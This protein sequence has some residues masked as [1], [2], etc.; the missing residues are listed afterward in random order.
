MSRGT[1]FLLGLVLALLVSLPARALPEHTWVVAI[2]HDQGAANEVGLLF[3]EQDAR[4][5][6]DVLRQHGG[7][8]SRRTMLLLGDDAASVRRALQ[9]VNAAIRSQAGAGH[10][11]AL[12]VFYSGHADAASLHLGGT[13][14]PFEELKALVEGSPAGV[15]LL[16]LDACRSGAVT[17]VKG[18]NAAQSFDISLRNNIATEGLAILTSSA[19]GESSQESD[20][21]RGSFFT[22]HLMN[23]LRGAAD[24]DDDGKVTLT[25]AYG[26]AYTQTLRSSGQ[27]VALQH[28][29][30]SWAVKGRGE[31]VLSTPAETQG[32]M[33]RVRLGSS[34]L[35]LILEGRRG[36]PVVAEV[37]PQGN[38][39]ELSLPA[40]HYFV[41]QRSADE[42]REYQVTLAAGAVAEVD[43]LP[44]ETVRYDRLVRRRGGEKRYTHH[45]SLLGGAQGEMLAGDGTAPQLRVGYGLDFDWG[46]VGVRLRGLR[47][48]SSGLDGLL[49][50]THDELG[51]GLTLQRFVDLAPVSLAFGLF[52]EGVYHRQSFDTERD[53]SN[54][55]ALGAAF[56]GIL[57][58]ERHL[59][60]GLA[61]RLEG[62]P[63]T[64]LFQRAV[65]KNGVVAEGRELATPLTWWGAGGLVWRR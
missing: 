51:L 39:R 59:G 7:V 60:A 11:T 38:R 54:R 30:Y 31:L 32:K 26:Y 41:Q 35:Y 21:L 20:E 2:G 58:V 61:L 45:V 55:Q 4:A 24:H 10:P 49:P 23:A 43:S 40:G 28:P 33:G 22:H 65:M 3:A 62:G 5:F 36:G 1:L 15:R 63:V 37:S 25:E 52:V 9:D 12:V 47:S 57:S 34:S 13:E 6:A 53:S 19:A 64:G 18:V 42:Y 17:R 44:F 14:L 27:T 56:G 16:V 8:S 50:R 29:T 48:Q 46:S